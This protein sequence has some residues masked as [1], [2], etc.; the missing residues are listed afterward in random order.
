MPKS[1]SGNVHF[2]GSGKYYPL[3]M[4]GCAKLFEFMGASADYQ[5]V[6]EFSHMNLF[7]VQE[8]DCVA[9]LGEG[10]TDRRALE[11]NSRLENA[12]VISSL[13]EFDEKLDEIA[14][15]VF[16]AIQLQYFALQLAQMRGFT[17]PAFLER[18]SLLK[19][20]SKMIY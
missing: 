18:R 16:Y 17:Q 12:G 14:Q 3:A 7:T 10:T 1:F 5:L 9:I 6:E 4:Y 13:L 11:L 8:N 19:V 15:A 2:V 20:S